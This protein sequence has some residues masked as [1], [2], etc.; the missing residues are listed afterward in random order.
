MAIDLGEHGGDQ[1]LCTV[2]EPLTW[3]HLKNSCFT[4]ADFLACLF[5]CLFLLY[6]ISTIKP[7]TTLLQ[8][9][10]LKYLS[11]GIIVCRGQ[12]LCSIIYHPFLIQWKLLP[13]MCLQSNTCTS[14]S[15]CNHLNCFP[16]LFTATISG[17][18]VFQGHGWINIK[19]L[20]LYVVPQMVHAET[21]P[22]YHLV[23]NIYGLLEYMAS[24]SEM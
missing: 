7:F 5:I 2:Y 23:I 24:R 6:P 16:L 3:G 1:S 12:L 8:F 17:H 20:F 11:K 14:E 10:V 9:T 4:G 13:R 19:Y 21:Q 15:I 22:Y 18:A